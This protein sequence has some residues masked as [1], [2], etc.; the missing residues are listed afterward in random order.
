MDCKISRTG[1]A[2]PGL[3]TNTAVPL[4]GKKVL[5]RAFRIADVED[6]AGI[7]SIGGSQRHETEYFIHRLRPSL[8]QQIL[9]CGG[10]PRHPMLIVISLLNCTFRQ[11]LSL[12]HTQA[13]LR[14]HIQQT[15]DRTMGGGGHC[16]TTPFATALWP[17]VRVV[18]RVR[19][20]SASFRTMSM[21][22]TPTRLG[23]R[24]REMHRKGLR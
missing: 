22:I 21:L 11:A 19:E 15:R 5:E 24:L 3:L 1:V 7:R 14:Y 13:A 10:I 9:R 6:G 2:A 4:R 20:V 23:H 16:E 18:I 12:N 8:A 17:A